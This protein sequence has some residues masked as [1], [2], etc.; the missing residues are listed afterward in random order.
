MALS[1]SSI[2]QVGHGALNASQMGIQTTGN[3]IANVNTKGYS[4]QGVGLAERVSLDG[5]VGQIGQ[6]VKATQI[7]RHFDRFI[8]KS[9]LEKNSSQSRYHTEYNRLTTV[10][11]LFNESMTS[12]IGGALS[13]L[14]SSFNKLSLEPNN[15]AV[16]ESLIQQAITLT[17]TIRST[18][19]S[20]EAYRLQMDSLI[21][22]DVAKANELVNQIA[23]LNREINACT[24]TGR[25]NANALM[26][27]RDLR[28]RELS[29]ILDISV[30]D[31]GAG[32]YNVSTAMGYALVQGDIAFSL[33]FSG[34]QVDAVLETDSKYQGSM[35]FEGTDGYE[36]TIEVVTGGLV[37]TTG[38]VNGLPGTAQYKVSLDGGRTWMTNDDGSVRLFNAT[39]KEHGATVKDLELYFTD[40]GSPLSA[41]DKFV[42][43]PKNDV[44]WVE[45]T[46][47]PINISSQVYGDGMENSLRITG[48][49][50]GGNLVFRDYQIGEY[51]DRLDAL[52]RNV[53]WEV[54][55]IH[56]QG[57]G[58]VK[59]N[60]ANGT[61]QVG[62]PDVPLGSIS[63]QFSWA[64]KLQ[65]GNVSFSIYDSVTGETV[66]PYP[67]IDV[68]SPENFDPEKHSLN[69]VMKAI[70]QGDA[71]EWLT[72]SVI[73]GRLS[74]TAKQGFEFGVVGDTTGL[75]AGL[76][77]NTFFSGDDAFSIAVRGDLTTDANLINAG[78]ING[79]GEG[80]SGDNLTATELAKLATKDINI[81]TYGS[82]AG[83]QTL[84]DY[85]AALVARVGSDTAGAKYTYAVES[86]M[87]QEYSDRRE[88]ISG[89]SLDEEMTNLI[90]FQSS[91]KAA[92]KLITTADE[93][94]QVLL[95][96]KQ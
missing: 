62:R 82:N 83:S 11:T 53:A 26:D 10:E 57:S 74:I 42:I 43:S 76:G 29:E 78:R 63:S 40:T 71:G 52:A 85:Y 89:V 46:S 6:G 27:E 34:R 60:S 2:L 66:I 30:Q 13:N 59:L 54:N 51:M 32:N 8:E 69:D 73:D 80:N 50:L 22:Q 49:S 21:S 87:A 1:L 12:G 72:A 75:L 55:R 67:G 14:F 39:D 38:T 24:V 68:F 94:L 86:A 70:N 16:R 79:A 47:E 3:N 45:P 44:Y 9:F 58:L 64:D 48:G 61:E 56:S 4:R 19:E 95:G 33:E 90:K 28:V 23:Y 5:P 91:Y 18:Q 31:D 84:V 17:S 96:L 35:G 20:M 41:G 37:D 92:A 15:M 25:N 88:E 77:I 65:S 93:M 36:Y 7:F 81:K